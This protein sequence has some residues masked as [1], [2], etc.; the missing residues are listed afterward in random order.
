MRKPIAAFLI[1]S[2][3]ALV[4]SAQVYNYNF[5]TPTQFTK[6]VN[7]A[8]GG[9]VTL[10]G[11]TTVT[12]AFSQTGS[13]GITLANG[14]SINTD[15]D[16]VFDLT[17]DDA[18]T[19]TLTCSDD[20]ATAALTVRPGGAAA[21][22]FGGSS[23]T[24]FTVTT[25]GTGT[26]EVVL[27]LQSI[28][29]GEIVNDTI[30]GTE[31]ADTITLDAALVLTGAVAINVG[32]SL[33]TAVTIATDGTGTGELVLPSESVAA[34]EITNLTRTENIPIFSLIECTTD[35]GALIGFDTTADALPDF[36]CSATDGLGCSL[37][38]DDTGGSVD[39][40]KACGALVVPDDYASGGAF[41]FRVTKDAES[42]AN[43]EVI[44]VQISNDA[45]ALEA[46]GTATVTTNTIA[47]Y[48]VT[49]TIAGLAAG[50]SVGF[51]VSITSGGTADDTVNIWSIGFEYTAVQ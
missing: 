24:S 38:F 1:F 33:A 39:T 2:L 34:G 41:V 17:R 28:A 23:M 26:G 27:P 5:D 43:T 48:T 15:T 35:A 12:G 25:D 18:G 45:A 50:E 40:A 19:V 11:T 32:N 46:A 14:E 3:V 22:V 21:G 4:A 37:T 7:F 6:T 8:S 9:T 10:A 31:L 16:D 42:A 36:A 20:D 13:G 47:E 51:T 44:N 49:P 29:A 30:D